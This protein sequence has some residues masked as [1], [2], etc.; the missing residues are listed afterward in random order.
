MWFSSK[1]FRWNYRS[2]KVSY[3]RCWNIYKGKKSLGIG[4][5]GLAHYLAKKGYRYDKKLAWRQVDKLTEAFQYYLVK[6]S[7]ELAEAKGKGE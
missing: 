6:S 7:K 1:K 2:S 3:K 5:I 4:Y